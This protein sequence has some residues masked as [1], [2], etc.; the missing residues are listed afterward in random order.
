MVNYIIVCFSIIFSMLFKGNI[1]GVVL[2]NNFPETITAGEQV[3]AGI[4][5]KKGDIT[6]YAKLQFEIPVGFTLSPIETKSASFTI[7]DQKAKLIW[8]NLPEDSEFTVTFKLTALA[9]ASGNHDITGNFS[10]LIDN[11]K[12]S[13][14]LPQ[15]KITIIEKSD[16]IATVLANSETNPQIIKTVENTVSGTQVQQTVAAE[17]IS[18]KE[19]SQKLDVKAPTQKINV[20]ESPEQAVEKTKTASTE[21]NDGVIYK[22]Q[23][24]VFNKEV[25]KEI[26]ELI[27]TLQDVS[28]HALEDNFT[29]YALG[30][31][32]SIAEAKERKDRIVS[33]GIENA[34]IAMV[35][36]GVYT[37]FVGSGSKFSAKTSSKGNFSDSPS[38]NNS[39]YL[40][41]P[42]VFHTEQTLSNEDSTDEIVYRVQLGAFTN[43][44]SKSAYSDVQNLIVLQSSDG[45]I[46]ILS[47]SYSDYKSAVREKQNI[48]QLGYPKAYIVGFKNGK[49]INVTGPL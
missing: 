30:D 16:A 31:Y 1:S 28:T 20:K 36:D 8:L 21:T 38:E 11:E 3:V 33:L 15:K 32:A 44:P 47:G 6:G 22:V 23:L 43:G 5:I 27:M 45:F 37:P 7:S 24:G 19:P 14:E 29:A 42:H 4:K 34:G 49:R 9:T 10:Y 26:I 39:N 35:K 12:K 48:V 40:S 2:E 46:R 41:A 25:P 13:A 17:K 18:V